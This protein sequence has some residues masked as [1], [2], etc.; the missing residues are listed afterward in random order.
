MFFFSHLVK[1]TCHSL[2]RRQQELDETQN[3]QIVKKK[4]LLIE[5]WRFDTS[6][7]N[8]RPLYSLVQVRFIE[9]FHQK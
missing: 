4:S 7:I 5:P 2:R 8:F 6:Q 3:L 1:S 9:Q